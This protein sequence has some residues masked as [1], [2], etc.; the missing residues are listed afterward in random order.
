MIGTRKS[1]GKAWGRWPLAGK[2]LIKQ[3]DLKVTGISKATWS[4]SSPTLPYIKIY[5]QKKRVLDIS[6]ADVFKELQGKTIKPGIRSYQFHFM[7]QAD[8]PPTFKD[9][10]AKIYYRI[11]IQSKNTCKIKKKQYFPFNVMNYLNLNHVSEFKIPMVYVLEK[12]FGNTADF[13]VTFKTYRG[14]ASTQQ[15]PFEVIITNVKR[16]KVRKICVTLIQKIEYNVNS[17]YY[18]NEKNI[19]K[20]EYNEILN[21]AKQTCMFSMEIPQVIIPSTINQ[22]EPMVDISYSLQ[23][24]VS[25]QFHLP[26]YSDIP[27][28]IASTP[29]THGIFYK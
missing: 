23:V 2:R 3:I 8:L 14:F 21:L 5:S 10:I 19:C 11:A 1:H 4:R 13:S 20:T 12:K 7:L 15:I 9:S 28:T 29:V 17:G 24:K 16:V 6:I 18:N 26:L 22:V 25:F 27:V